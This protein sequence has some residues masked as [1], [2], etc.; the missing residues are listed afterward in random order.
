MAIHGCSRPLTFTRVLARR[1]AAWK[2]S[3]TIKQVLLGIQALLADPNNADPAQEAPHRAFNNDLNHYEGKV[4][5]QVRLL[6]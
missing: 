6:A 1:P 2:P 5:E 3:L 4:K